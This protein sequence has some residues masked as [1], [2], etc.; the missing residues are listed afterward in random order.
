MILVSSQTSEEATDGN[1]CEAL[2]ALLGFC[3]SLFR[4]HCHP[5]ILAAADPARAYR[6]F[7]PRCARAVSDYQEGS[8]KTHFGIPGMGTRLRPKSQDPHTESREGRE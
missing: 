1:L 8:G 2:W 3:I 5:G 7:L 6:A 4:P